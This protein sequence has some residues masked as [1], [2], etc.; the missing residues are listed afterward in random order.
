MNTPMLIIALC[1]SQVAGTQIQ[2]TFT[3]KFDSLLLLEAVDLLLDEGF[4]HGY[5]GVKS[6][7]R[8]GERVGNLNQLFA[9]GL[10]QFKLVTGD[11]FTR[12]RKVVTLDKVLLASARE[13]LGKEHYTLQLPVLIGGIRNYLADCGSKT[14]VRVTFHDPDGEV[15]IGWFLFFD[16]TKEKKWRLDFACPLLTSSPNITAPGFGRG[17]LLFAPRERF[18]LPTLTIEASCSNR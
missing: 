18:E 7:Y 5:D 12:A 16:I 10:H 1:F 11:N 6:V 4:E 9:N 2:P 8:P 3:E 13:E 15:S 14:V 17:F